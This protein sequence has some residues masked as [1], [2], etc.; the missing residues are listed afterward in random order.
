MNFKQK[1]VHLT[2]CRGASWDIIYTILKKDPQLS[3]LYDLHFHSFLSPFKTAASILEDLNSQR[4]RENILQYEQN[5]IGIVTIFDH[6][7]P[8]LLKET[9]KPPWVLYAKGD[10][11]LLSA[12]KRLA[13]VGSRQ[14]TAFGIK[15]IELLFPELIK[16][17]AVIVSGLAAGIDA[18]AHKTAIRYGGRTIG[19][20]AGG[21]GHIYPE[22]NEHLAKGMMLRQLVLS[23]YPPHARPQKWH[24]PMRNRIIAG[25]SHGTLIIEAKKRSGSLITADYALHEGREVFAVPGHILS[26]YSVGT[27]ELIQQ[28]AKLVITAKDIL[29]ELK[30]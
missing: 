6:E 17:Q 1:L 16:H 4:I 9:Y 15:S 24:F 14:A 10:L 13:V 26:P 8:L 3:S 29:E 2:L 7:Y 30:I 11:S 5:H 23:E 27:N 20:I 25:I 12:K 21:F 28:G 18:E 19:I 22:Q